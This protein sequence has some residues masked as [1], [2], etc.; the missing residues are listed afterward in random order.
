[1]PRAK[2]PKEPKPE[3]P[4]DVVFITCVD[5]WLKDTHPGWIFGGVQ[6]KSLKGII[7]NIKKTWA[8]FKIIA[9]DQQQIESFQKI[10]VFLLTDPWFCDKDLQIIYSKYN[11][12]VLKMQQGK[13]NGQTYQNQPSSKR[14]FGPYG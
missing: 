14:T 1:M 8:N 13:K 6:G 7:T 4:K 9:S 3:K 12:I 11:E 5:I 10:C 2:K